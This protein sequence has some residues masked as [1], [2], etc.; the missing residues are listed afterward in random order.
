M[1]GLRGRTRHGGPCER[2]GVHQACAQMTVSLRRSRCVIHSC[3][4]ATIRRIS[5]LIISIKQGSGYGRT[6][7]SLNFQLE[8]LIK[9]PRRQHAFV[10][11]L[12]A[13][14]PYFGTGFA[15][16]RVLGSVCNDALGVDRVALMFLMRGEAYHEE[17][18]RRWLD[19]AA[20]L[21]PAQ[22]LQARVAVAGRCACRHVA[23]LN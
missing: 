8:C 4:D 13:N 19:S 17:L 21:L 22:A 23:R 12:V 20:G 16:N 5:P 14:L 15:V 1:T 11:S 9:T 3:R 18:W 7:P 2:F 6:V 10:H